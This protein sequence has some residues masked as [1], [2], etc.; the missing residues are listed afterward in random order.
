MSVVR[1]IRI[2]C[3][4]GRETELENRLNAVIAATRVDDDCNGYQWFRSDIARDATVYINLSQWRAAA[5][6]ERHLASD[7][8]KTFMMQEGADPCLTGAP[9]HHNLIEVREKS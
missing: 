4:P 3:R 6:W 8:F 1:L 7:G 2:T 5:G 9:E